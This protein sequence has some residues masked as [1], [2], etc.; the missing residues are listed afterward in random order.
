MNEN[1]L[2][3]LEKFAL[4]PNLNI[5]GHDCDYIV[6]NKEEDEGYA[7]TLYYYDKRYIMDWI[8]DEH[9]SILDFSGNTPEEAIDEAFDFCKNNNLIKII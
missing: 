8:G 1:K 6:V 3:A 5:F 4:L 7:P 2:N 9:D